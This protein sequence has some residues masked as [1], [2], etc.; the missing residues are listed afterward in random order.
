MPDGDLRWQVRAWGKWVLDWARV[1]LARYYPIV[2]GQPTVAYFWARTVR[3]IQTEGGIPILHTFLLCRKK[4][5]RVALLP[6]PDTAKK[7]VTFKLLTEENLSTPERRARVIEDYPILTRWGVTGDTLEDFLKKGTKSDA[8]VWS[9]FDKGRPDLLALTMEEI[10]EQGRRGLMDMQMTAICVE[11]KINGKKKTEKH[12]R[13]P[14][15]DELKLADIQDEDIEDVFNGIPYGV[16][17]DPLPPQGSL[18]F[19]VQLYGLVNWRHL[20]S[21]R[22]LLAA[23]VFLKHTREAITALRQTDPDNAEALAVYLTVIFGR[24]IDYCSM[25]CSWEPSDGEVKHTIAG[26]KLPMAWNFAEANPLSVRD[27]YYAG[28]IRAISDAIGEFVRVCA[29]APDAPAVRCVSS[30]A[31]ELSGQDLCFTDPPYYDAIPYADLMNFFRIWQKRILVISMQSSTRSSS[32]PRL[33][34]M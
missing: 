20:F 2:N 5:K 21:S 9:P 6:V 24:F 31:T 10:R 7:A 13:L 23:G 28:G 16:I 32:G 15:E 18:G 25:Q 30:L 1:E 34:G 14:T 22:Q 26:Y 11:G 27:R 19:R 12:Y 3:D 17:D 8:G 29:K 4:G 33:R